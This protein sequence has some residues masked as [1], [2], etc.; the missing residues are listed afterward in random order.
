MSLSESVNRAVCQTQLQR[1]CPIR[2]CPPGSMPAAPAAHLPSQ[3]SATQMAYQPPLQHIFPLESLLPRQCASRRCSASALSEFCD[4]DSILAAVAAHLPSQESA[5]Q[6]VRH[7]PVQRIC[8]LKSQPPRQHAS[9]PCSAASF[10]KESAARA[11]CLD[12]RLLL[13][14]RSCRLLSPCSS[15]RPPGAFM[16][17]CSAQRCGCS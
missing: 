7:L 9:C 17:S 1:I 14:T 13:C 8:P 10:S 6:A 11:C 3:A 16:S 2:L 4:P 15:P 12:G 5:T